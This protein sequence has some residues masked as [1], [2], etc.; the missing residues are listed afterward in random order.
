MRLL[1]AGRPFFCIN[2]TVSSAMLS[3]MRRPA[4]S[5]S[6]RATLRSKPNDGMAF[7]DLDGEGQADIPKADDADAGV[8]EIHGLQ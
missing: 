6:I 8:V 5:S 3:L 2:L 1:S 7:A 4:R